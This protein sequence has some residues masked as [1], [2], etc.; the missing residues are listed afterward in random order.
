MEWLWKTESSETKAFQDKFFFQ[1]KFKEI[2]DTK[3]I[4]RKELKALL[5]AGVPP[6]LRGDVWFR[7]S[8]AN[9][10]KAWHYHDARLNELRIEQPQLN[11]RAFLLK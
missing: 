8:G 9:I 1:K 5:R 2:F 10:K 11:A 7:L 4:A 3:T 6:E